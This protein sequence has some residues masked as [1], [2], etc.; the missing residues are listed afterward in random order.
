MQRMLE[1]HLK[2]KTCSGG[3]KWKAPL[4]DSLH[5][6]QKNLPVPLSSFV[7]S[8]PIRLFHG[9]PG[10]CT[11]RN[12]HKARDGKPNTLTLVKLKSG[13]IVGG[14]T[15]ENNCGGILGGP[16]IAPANYDVYEWNRG[17]NGSNFELNVKG[18]VLVGRMSQYVFSG[19]NGG[20]C[21]FIKEVCGTGS[22]QGAIE[23]CE[24]YRMR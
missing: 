15:A 9:E 17:L 8:D 6:I 1:F 5:A 19:F 10:V 11:D 18:H 21:A 24:V 20:G 7:A 3:N 2:G 12:L 14:Y 13:S 16:Y 22:S 23:C 4:V